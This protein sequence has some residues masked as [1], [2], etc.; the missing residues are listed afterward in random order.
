MTTMDARYD[1]DDDDAG[2]GQREGRG[3]KGL[4]SRARGARGED[5]AVQ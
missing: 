3:A 4:V 5:E 1:D 2:L